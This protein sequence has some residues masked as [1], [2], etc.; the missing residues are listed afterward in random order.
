MCIHD[1]PDMYCLQAYISAKSLMHMLQLLHNFYHDNHCCF[2][3][4]QT[5][6]VHIAYVNKSNEVI[7]VNSVSV[8]L[9]HPL[10]QGH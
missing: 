7:N 2:C 10:H 8:F 3:I 5:F 6:C 9:Q 1:L 4:F